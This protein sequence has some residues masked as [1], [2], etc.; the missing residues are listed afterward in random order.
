MG[1][2]EREFPLGRVPTHFGKINQLI[3]EKF[4]KKTYN[5]P[6]EI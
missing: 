3:E 4:K 6:P 1:P 2:L 5:T